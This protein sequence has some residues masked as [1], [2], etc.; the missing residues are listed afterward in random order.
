MSHGEKAVGFGK[1]SKQRHG[2]PKFW[3]LGR[4]NPVERRSVV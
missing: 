2:I 3:I 4:R 1:S